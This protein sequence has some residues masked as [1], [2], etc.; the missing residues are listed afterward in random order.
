MSD[1]NYTLEEVK[2]CLMA[3]R[4]RVVRGTATAM[5]SAHFEWEYPLAERFAKEVVGTLAPDNF[6]RP[7]L[8]RDGT[9]AD[10]YGIVHASYSWYVK[11]FVDRGDDLLVI[12]SCHLPQWDVPTRAGV[13][14]CTHH[15]VRKP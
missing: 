15:G 13:V 7:T 5:I 1:P 12:A 2:R 3:R 9:P 11:L 4:V 6:S 10:E 14:T 8:M